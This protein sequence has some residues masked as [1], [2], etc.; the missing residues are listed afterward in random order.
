MRN[1]IKINKDQIVFFLYILILVLFTCIHNYIFFLY[2]LLLLLLYKILIKKQYYKKSILN[3]IFFSIFLSSIFVGYNFILTKRLEIE[4]FFLFNLRVTS[5]YLFT[6]IIITS[7]SI[8]KVFEFSQKG[9]IF[10]TLLLNIMVSYERFYREYLDI[11]KSKG[12]FILDLHQK[13]KLLSYIIFLFFLKLEEDWKE[14][15]FIMESRGFYFDE[16]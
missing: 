12:F 5:I 8:F 3:V 6:N 2:V 15:S 7:I 9:T 16:E 4:Y 11:L 13:I 14:I 1:T 10:L